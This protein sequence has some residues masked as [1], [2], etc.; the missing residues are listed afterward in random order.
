MKTR[1]KLI[2]TGATMTW[3]EIGFGQWSAS[4]VQAAR[5]GDSLPE[6]M[7]RVAMKIE[8]PLDGGAANRL[9]AMENE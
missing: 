6:A 1:E 8:W 2:V 5:L 9:L 7:R 4:K 3:P